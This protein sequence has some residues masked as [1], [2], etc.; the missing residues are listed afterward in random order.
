MI[1]LK[2]NTV[3]RQAKIITAIRRIANALRSFYM[4]N[5]KYSGVKWGGIGTLVR[6]PTSTV[7]WSPHK[8]VTI[9]DR[10]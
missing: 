2:N 8:D 1:D 9:G 7:I 6:I 10:V 3:P 4:L 5:I